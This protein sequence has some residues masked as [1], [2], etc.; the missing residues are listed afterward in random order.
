MTGIFKLK[1]KIITNDH[2]SIPE[3]SLF[4]KAKQG[5]EQSLFVALHGDTKVIPLRNDLFDY[6]ED[7]VVLSDPLLKFSKTLR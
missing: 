7:K 6:V 5:D 4:Y 3:G 2:S 1:E